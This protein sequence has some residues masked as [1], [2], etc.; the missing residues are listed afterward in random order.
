[1]TTSAPAT[2]VSFAWRVRC[3]E[4]A[5]SLVPLPV[6][7]GMVTAAATARQ[8]S[9]FSA[10]LNTGPSPVVPTTTRPSLPCS[11]SQRASE[12]PCVE[13]EG[14]VVGE[15]RDHCRQHFAESRHGKPYL[16]AHDATR[17]RP[18]AGNR[19]QSP[20]NSLNTIVRSWG[21][22]GRGTEGFRQV[23]PELGRRRA[24]GR[25]AARP[26]RSTSRWWG[27]ARSTR[28]SRPSPSPGASW[29]RRTSTSSASRPSPTSR[30]TG[31]AARPSAW[32]WRTGPAA[33][34]P[35]NPASAATNPAAPPTQH[36]RHPRPVATD[37]GTPPTTPHRPRRRH[38][39]HVE[40]DGRRGGRGVRH[41][42]AGGGEPRRRR[43][44]LL[45]TAAPVLVPGPRPTA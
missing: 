18:Y 1:M 7:T 5:V 28:R 30:S 16:A 39:Q 27:P 15:G 45:E 37:A 6:M 2:P 19:A 11:L 34:R 4:S 9:S 36:A 14:T 33:R 23:Q 20:S 26:E 43:P 32:R 22:S 8:R 38:H 40:H 17:S 29:R 24:G 25:A 44:R 12:R 3:T 21:R 41:Q 13:V 42:R 31:R 10:S 35:T